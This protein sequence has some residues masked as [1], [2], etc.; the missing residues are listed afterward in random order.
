M[1]G[2]QGLGATL[3]HHHRDFRPGSHS[4]PGQAVRG[5][6]NTTTRS[7]PALYCLLNYFPHYDDIYDNIRVAARHVYLL[8]KILSYQNCLNVDNDCILDS[9]FN[10]LEMT[11]GNSIHV[12]CPLYVSQKDFNKKV[13]LNTAKFRK[14][15]I[16]F[17]ITTISFV[18][19][20]SVALTCLYF[21]IPGKAGGFSCAYQ[22]DRIQLTNSSIIKYKT[23][24]SRNLP[25]RLNQTT[26]IFQA[27]VEG[28][29][30]V[31]FGYQSS[32][33]TQVE[34]FKNTEK[35][36]SISSNDEA[37]VGRSLYLTLTIEDHVQLECSDCHQLK[38]IHFCIANF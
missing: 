34:L 22:P 38:N 27:S 2:S 29:Y 1:R 13:D 37:T 21:S 36:L 24:D 12:P 14:V 25:S 32:G 31:T 4:L 18:V 11:N 28:I 8:Q 7:Q 3:G 23:L 16:L 30:S 5:S 6:V 9:S 10:S 33:M 19:A 26:G 15:K 17:L 20:T 35:I